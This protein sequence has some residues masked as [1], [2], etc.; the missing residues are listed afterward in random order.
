[1]CKIKKY[2]TSKEI[3]MLYFDYFQIFVKQITEIR[4]DTKYK[5]N[6]IK[7]TV[8]AITKEQVSN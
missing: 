2:S 3:K 1:M 6:R 7:H 8:L 4:Y 5:H